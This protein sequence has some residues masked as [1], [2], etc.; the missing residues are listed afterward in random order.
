M[1][2]EMGRVGVT[3]EWGADVIPMGDGT[4][5]KHV[6]E[7]HTRGAVQVLM[8]CVIRNDHEDVHDTTH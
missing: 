7:T 4:N 6:L 8:C 2:R 3:Q 5:V 1:H